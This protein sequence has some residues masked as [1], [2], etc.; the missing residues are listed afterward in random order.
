MQNLN[1]KSKTNSMKNS[2]F[3]V[4]PNNILRPIFK[5]RILLCFVVRYVIAIYTAVLNK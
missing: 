3:F 1:K 4:I 2:G 5:C